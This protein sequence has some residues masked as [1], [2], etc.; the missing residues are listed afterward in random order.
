MLHNERKQFTCLLQI[1]VTTAAY[2]LLFISLVK[3]ETTV[4]AK[5]SAIEEKLQHKSS[6][7]KSE[8]FHVRTK[9]NENEYLN[10]YYANYYNEYYNNYYDRVTNVH[11][12]A[13]STRKS[14]IGFIESFNNNLNVPQ[15]G[16]K[17]SY[18]PILKYR[19]T[20]RKR[21]KLFVPV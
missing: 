13:A 11:N 18:T 5:P 8:D 15:G 1:N 9:R 10:E 12:N 2:V 3:L 20:H 7:S 21:K 6:I 17:Y 19:S 14:K 16:T 4:S